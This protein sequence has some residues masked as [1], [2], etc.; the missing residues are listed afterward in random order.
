[1]AGFDGTPTQQNTLLMLG[2]TA[3]HQLRILIVDRPTAR[4]YMAREGFIWRNPELDRCATIT[5]II[6]TQLTKMFA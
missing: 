1:M 3:D 5:A 6:H 2:N 4:T